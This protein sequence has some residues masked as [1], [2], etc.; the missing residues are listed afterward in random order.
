MQNNTKNTATQ[1]IDNLQLLT[2]GSDYQQTTN[3]DC[4][5]GKSFTHRPQTLFVDNYCQQVKKVLNMKY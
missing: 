4:F 5:A 1:N 3:Y 2:L